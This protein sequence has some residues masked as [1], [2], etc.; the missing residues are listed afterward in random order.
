MSLTKDALLKFQ[1]STIRIG[2]KEKLLFSN[3]ETFLIR[4]G[5]GGNHVL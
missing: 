5:I 3:K 4:K 2:S 1:F